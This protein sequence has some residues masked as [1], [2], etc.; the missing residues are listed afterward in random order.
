MTS[1][2]SDFFSIGYNGTVGFRDFWDNGSRRFT[3]SKTW[4]GS[5]LYLNADPCREL[6]ITLREEY[7]G[8]KNSETFLSPYVPFPVHGGLGGSVVASTLSF[9]LKLVDNLVLIPEFRIDA[10]SQPVFV[11]VN[12]EPA[13][14]T[15][16]FLLALTY[17]F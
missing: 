8:D 5:A 15:A 9:N 4:W 13:K 10:A 1:K 16:S 6:G 2:L 3:G 12:G 17:H 14:S 11:K 7:F